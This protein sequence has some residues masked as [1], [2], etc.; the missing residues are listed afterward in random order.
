MLVLSVAACAAASRG[1]L[2]EVAFPLLPDDSAVSHAARSAQLRDAM[3]ELDDISTKRLPAELEDEPHQRVNL[4]QVA[5][6]AD[7]LGHAAA[8]IPDSLQTVRLPADEERRLRELSEQLVRDAFALR[9]RAILGEVGSVRDE[10]EQLLA[11]CN[12]CHAF[13]RPVAKT[14]VTALRSKPGSRHN[15]EHARPR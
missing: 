5:N 11:T 1:R 12:A 14:P 3:Y 8:E 2:A 15:H 9:D 7:A 4:D 13:S 6:L 10:T